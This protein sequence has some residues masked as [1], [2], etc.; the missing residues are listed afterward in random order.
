[1]GLDVT[2]S[3]AQIIGGIIQDTRM[4]L[5]TNFI[6]KKDQK[7]D[8]KRSIYTE[9]LNALMPEVKYYLKILNIYVVEEAV[10]SVMNRDFIKGWTM[11]FLYSEGNYSRAIYF[12]ISILQSKEH[13]KFSILEKYKQNEIGFKRA[14]IF[15]DVLV[16]S[17]LSEI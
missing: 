13:N 15:I 2:C 5:D 7:V 6:V 12:D 14:Q 4:L 11:R 10:L 9:I 3:G 8:S 1:M 17:C 16:Y